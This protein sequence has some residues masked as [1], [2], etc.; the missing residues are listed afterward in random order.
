LRCDG[1]LDRYVAYFKGEDWGFELGWRLV[2]EGGVLAVVSVVG[3][4][5]GED[6]GAR[7][8]GIDEAAVLK[9][10]GIQGAHE[11][12]GPGVVIWVGPV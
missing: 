4:D 1:F 12:F 3:I 5:V 10:F 2:A 7:I 8:V 9:H 6:L 11:G